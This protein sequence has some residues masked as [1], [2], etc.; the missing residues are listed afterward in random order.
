MRYAF[1]QPHR[2]TMGKRQGSTDV[3]S[4]VQNS[5]MRKMTVTVYI[6]YGAG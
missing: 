5:R 3:E 1:G 2:G 4:T 6:I